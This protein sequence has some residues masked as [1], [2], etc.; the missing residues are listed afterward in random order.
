[1]VNIMITYGEEEKIQ[2]KMDGMQRI[3]IPMKRRQGQQGNDRVQSDG[4]YQVGEKQSCC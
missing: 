4:M 1:M 2:K 3:I